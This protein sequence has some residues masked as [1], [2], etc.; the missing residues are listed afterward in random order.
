M[1]RKITDDDIVEALT[2]TGSADRT[3]VEALRGTS[4]ESQRTDNEVLEAL[5]HT[6]ARIVTKGQLPLQDRGDE[7]EAVRVWAAQGAAAHATKALAE[8]LMRSDPKKGI[9]AA[10]AEAKGLAEEAYAE[11]AKTL[12]YE[13][14]RQE[15]V[16]AFVTKLAERLTRP[17]LQEASRRAPATPASKKPATV[18]ETAPAGMTKKTTI[19]HRTGFPITYYSK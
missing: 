12:R 7:L 19:S 18:T 4:T 13:D 5:G 1:A 3:V 16:K 9:Y 10:E 2:G 17:R 11:A 14:D 6:P 8:A 15:H